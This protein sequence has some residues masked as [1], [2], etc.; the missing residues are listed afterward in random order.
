MK[1][2]SRRTFSG[3]RGRVLVCITKDSRMRL[4]DAVQ[5]LRHPLEQQRTVGE[6][7]KAVSDDGLLIKL[8]GLFSPVAIEVA[9]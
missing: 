4:C 9:S 6:L 8:A 1:R 5:P 3:N 2:E 7:V